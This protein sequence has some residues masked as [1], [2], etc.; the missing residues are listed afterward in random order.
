MPSKRI[1]IPIVL[2]LLAAAGAWWFFSSPGGGG[3]ALTAI[4]Q[5]GTL[6]VGVRDDTSPFVKRDRQGDIVG[7]EPD[8]A[9]DL[10]E[11][12]GVEL[13]LKAVKDEDR[14]Q[15]LQDGAVDLM[16]AGMPRR[17]GHGDLIWFV[18]PAYYAGGANVLVRMSARLDNWQQLKGSSVCAVQGA[19]YNETVAG[20]FG[21][22]VVVFRDGEEALRA[23]DTGDCRALLSDEDWLISLLVQPDYA[24]Y[25]MPL[26]HIEGRHWYVAT[27]H[28][29]PSLH[30]FIAR[31]V[32]DWHES[33]KIVELEQKWNVRPSGFAARMHGGKE[34][35]DPAGGGA[36]GGG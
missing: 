22:R 33:G 29:R 9:R 17:E 14:V 20:Q 13:E 4:K 6:I 30:K 5:R 18:E 10:A 19:D 34:G 36:A 24:D 23:F 26:S 32:K 1:I 3:G 25:D 12:L 2:V 31:A 7:L 16:L 15:A 27:R 8:L 28:N 35:A 21:A 11:R